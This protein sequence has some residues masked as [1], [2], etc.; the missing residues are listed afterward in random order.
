MVP[1]LS[2]LSHWNGHAQAPANTTYNSLWGWSGNGREYAILG[3][4]DTIYFFDVTDPVHIKLCSA[5]A[6]RFNNCLNREFKTYK[7]YCYAVADEGHSSLQIFDMKY[8]PDSV[9]K[10]YDSD[11]LSTCAHS[12]FIEH[13]RLYL[14]W[15]K[16]KFT[17]PGVKSVN[18]PN[19]VLTV[20][21][22]KNP[23]IPVFISNLR[24]PEVNVNGQIQTDFEYV[25]D[26]YVRND[27]A[28][29]CCGFSGL[30]IYNYKDSLSP[31]LIQILSGYDY[32]GFN[33]S[34]Y[35]TPNSNMLV[36]T[37]ETNSSPVKLYDVSEIK[38]SSR[39]QPYLFPV[40]LFGSH[41]SEGSI[42]H[43]P[44]IKGNLIIVSYYQ[45]GVVI[46]DMSDTSHVKEIASY[47]TYPQNAPG[48]YNGFQGCWNVYPY[49]ASGN[50]IASDITN[51]LFVL[52]M[53]SVSAVNSN[54]ISDNQFDIKILQNP[55][56]D[57]I[58][59]AL[60]TNTEQDINVNVY[61][62]VGKILFAS[63][64]HCPE[65]RTQITIP[66]PPTFRGTL[67]LTVSSK[68]GIY[69]RKLVKT[70]D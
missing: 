57:N 56:R 4:L 33:H 64:F 41:S 23:E 24:P 20:A 31:T 48:V 68:N 25:H 59:L 40:C 14:A 63:P 36:F 9:H 29:C 16:R 44:Y 58:N 13:D 26:L 37:D 6:G 18:E 21:S 46:F 53:D 34:C 47:D 55:F 67:L 70:G 17:I 11:T 10:V 50:L 45:D 43:N 2:L 12:L 42:A 28:Y 19:D 5:Q 39:I 69:S 15:N 38:D 65:G 30:F 61:D 60:Y 8:L 51:G 3:S 54:Y 1:H 66:G 32:N 62:M 7:N 49:F 22:L 27:T 35:L 52:G